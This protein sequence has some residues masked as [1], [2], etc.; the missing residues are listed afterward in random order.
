MSL[1]YTDFVRKEKSAALVMFIDEEEKLLDALRE[2]LSS[3]G[4]FVVTSNSADLN[5]EK[6]SQ[7]NPD[8]YVL[9]TMLTKT[10]ENSFFKKLEK[11][12]KLSNTPFIFLT[13]KGMTKDRIEGYGLGCSAYITKPFDPAELLAIIKNVL[14]KQKNVKEI[15]KITSKIKKVRI[16]IETYYYLKQYLSLTPREK[17]VIDEVILGSSNIEIAFKCNTSTR[18]I[19]KYITKLLYK[20]KTK[21]RT[22]LT[23]FVYGIPKYQYMKAEDGNRTRE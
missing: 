5:L 7:L 17:T 18:N 23:R 21:N 14:L 6:I 19:E 2:Y 15:C 10:K 1:K 20:T 8:V 12:L 22:E 9:D 16:E 11:S 4:F 13:S 3:Q